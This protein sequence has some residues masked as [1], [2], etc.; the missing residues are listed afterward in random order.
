MLFSIDHGNSAV[1]TPNFTFTSGLADY[2]ACRNGCAGVC[3][4]VLDTVR[5]AHFLYAR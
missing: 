2:P 5:A 1:K 3:R 4:K